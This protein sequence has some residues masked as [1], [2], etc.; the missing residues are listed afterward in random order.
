MPRKA[1]VTPT[2]APVPVVPAEPTRSG[3]M[4]FSDADLFPAPA[5]WALMREQAQVIAASGFH[6]ED[7][8][9]PEKLLV[10]MLR[11]RAL[12]LEPTQAIQSL[13]VSAEGKITM[14]AEL[15]RALVARSGVGTLTPT[16]F[17]DDRVTVQAI[18]YGQK[19]HPD[20]VTDFTMTADDLRRM[21]SRMDRGLPRH[22]LFA[23]VTS[24]AGR[25]LFSDVLAGVVYTPEELAD[26]PP[27]PP[28]RGRPPKAASE[29]ASGVPILA[30]AAQQD[31]VP[32]EALGGDG[33]HPTDPPPD[34]V[35]EQPNLGGSEPVAP[36]RPVGAPKSEVLGRE[37]TTV[38]QVQTPDGK[39][40]PQWTCGLTLPQLNRIQEL[41]Q[42][43]PTLKALAQAWLIQRGLPQE[44]GLRYCTAEEGAALVTH[45]EAEVQAKGRVTPE[46]LTWDRAYA[47]LA[48]MMEEAEIDVRLV[49]QML[50][51]QEE[52]AD[53]KQI[54]PRRLLQIAD[55]MMAS[56]R[57]DPQAVKLVL[58]RYR[59]EAPGAQGQ[60]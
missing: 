56:V 44:R 58:E 24:E 18:R 9:T 34:R 2:P 28:K 37:F 46:E 50:C 8:D 19:G 15:M 22:S 55:E 41:V 23:R 6:P 32:D 26:T 53:L 31:V 38:I 27:P 25:A 36:S 60:G 48:R 14:H 11:G 4:R 35:P 40:L 13:Y 49:S 3:A 52:I 43:K 33:Y 39:A 1:K 16:E 10:V 17:T 42:Q 47:Y 59:L 12:G 57:V 54:A 29:P 30:P 20:Q 5:V 45:L 51:A 7:L 21:G